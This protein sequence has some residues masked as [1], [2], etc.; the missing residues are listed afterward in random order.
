MAT[1]TPEPTPSQSPSAQDVDG[2]E[3]GD[4]D[5]D[6]PEPSP[7]P[8]HPPDPDYEPEPRRT[9]HDGRPSDERRA[10]ERKQLRPAPP[11]DSGGFDI[12]PSHVYYVSSLVRDEQFALHKALNTMVEDAHCRQAAG[13]GS[14][15]DDF[16]EA[17]AKVAAK[18]LAVWSRSIQSVGGVSLGLTETANNYCAAEWFSRGMY[19]PPPRQSPPIGVGKAKYGPLADIQWTGTGDGTDIPLVAGLGDI[20]DWLSVV[21]EPA[22]K[23]GLRLGRT[24]DITPGADT[25][26]LRKVGSAWHSAGVAAK[27]VAG[28]LNGH[29]GY[30]TNE[31][32]DDWR[33]AMHGFC[34]QIWG[35]T[36]WGAPRTRDGERVPKGQQQPD[37]REW[38]TN[39]K[40]KPTDR[41]PIIEI[42]EK[43]ADAVKKELDHVARIADTTRDTTSRLGAEA[44]KAT[45]KDLTMGLDL[46]ELT[47]LAGTLVFAEIVSTFRSHMDKE[48]VNRA[49][50]AYQEAFHS[51]A[52][53]LRKLLPELEEAQHS[54]PTYASEVARAQAFG[55]RSL[56]EFRNRHRWTKK[57][58][59][60]KGKY[61]VDLAGSEWLNNS[62]TAN[63]HVGLTDD[64]LAQRLR[65]DLKKP[66]RPGTE[67]PH[68][69]PQIGNAST[70]KDMESAQKMTQY[71]IDKNSKEIKDWLKSPSGPLVIETD[72]TPY[73][74]SGRSIDRHELKNN[75]Y[76]VDRAEDV[77][78]V[79]AKL[80]YDASLD[81]PFTVLTSMPKDVSG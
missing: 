71:T 56:D 48:A 66:P 70:F 19:G 25:G 10:W 38:R 5:A 73:G 47:R 42:L 17:Y 60:D 15:P 7:S 75:P 33:A 11:D 18:F 37:D 72:K 64:Q 67:W 69:Q 32:N 49:V 40:V 50:D 77:H 74:V 79:Q 51:G 9:G 44:A 53:E 20:P 28:K 6:R 45:V 76:P 39:P 54:A 1:P 63:K 59:T 36:P 8:G 81:P 65:D 22:I 57:N 16:A 43:T 21:I 61:T 14:G 58:D 55:A 12:K 46:G 29:M 26:D 24:H 52:A 30:L 27:G 35:T 13:K 78:G 62:H 68:G 2:K 23:E 4:A 3:K 34:Q 80:V 41:R 31:R